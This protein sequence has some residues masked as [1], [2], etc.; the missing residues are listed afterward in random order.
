MFGRSSQRVLVRLFVL[1]GFALGLAPSVFAA[2]PGLALNEDNSHFFFNRSAADMTRDGLNAFVD[3]YADTG[4]SDLFLC[5]NA[6]RANFR[7]TTRDAIW[8]VGNQQMPT[9]IGKRWIDNA[10]LLDKRG[11]DPYAIW[12]ARCRQKGIT[13]WLSMRMND[14]HNVNNVKNYMHSTFWVEH[15]Q[16]WRVPG[17]TS[18]TDRA[19]DYGIPEVRAYNIAFVKELLQRY[20]PDGIELDWMRFGYHF[21]PGQ[22]TE[23]R[24][25]LTGL[26]RD[27]RKLTNEWSKRRKHPIRLAARVPAHPDAAAGLG[28][29]GV[30][31]ARDGLVDM[32]I[33][34]PFWTTSDFDIPM[35]LWRKRLGKA[36]ANVTLAAGL[37][38]NLRPFPGGP[39]VPN[40][41]ASVR[42]FITASLYR[43]ADQIY[44][45][46]FMDSDTRPVSALDYRTL[47]KDGADPAAFAE[48]PQRYVV[49]FRDTVPP[50]FP[51]GVQLPANALRGGHF[52]IYVGPV[53]KNAKVT[54]IAGL[55][56]RPGVETAIFETDL[57]DVECHT[58][59]DLKKPQHL[60][61]LGRFIQFRG[62]TGALREG[63]NQVVIKQKG[64]D[65]GQRID[66]VELRIDP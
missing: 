61:P 20:D 9:G 48:K 53:P 28:M 59:P 51:N 11:L 34:T 56:K 22:E 65:A 25:I 10:R 43:G 33:A 5:P 29:D 4:V 52:T 2:K 37:E 42:G 35:E 55:A 58:L 12:I 21:K 62:P 32:L 46:N 66:W 15:P 60:P 27:V 45:F 41:L 50:G 30:T 26:M 44:L 31:W 63:Q 38:Y 18:W 57:N 13:P 36:A 19:L 16:Y 54:V 47:L 8:D 64:E 6:M 1:A 3:Q 7:S 24:A 17:G 14:L 49:C 39:A 23:G 40:D